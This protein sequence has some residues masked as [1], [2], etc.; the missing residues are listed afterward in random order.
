MRLR[1][2]WPALLVLCFVLLG[3]KPARAACT[4]SATGVAFG[5][6]NVFS[7]TPLDSTGTV[8]YTCQRGD[9][10]ITVA[11]G[12]G[13]S[14]TY[15]TRTMRQGS[16]T[17]NYNIYTSTA[18]SGLWG[19]GTG[20]TYYW[21]DPDPPDNRAVA[22]TMYGRIPAQQDVSAGVYTDTIQVLVNF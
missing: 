11:L 16:Q 3:A 7:T 5:T 4:V 2:I 8:T 9:A 10:R 12:T 6:Y 15:T 18:F 19:N 17:L 20:G 13:S 22:I 21:Y 14:G 1:R